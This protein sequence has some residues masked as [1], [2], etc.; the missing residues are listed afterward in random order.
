MLKLYDYFRSSAC[1]RV[2]IALNLKQLDYHIV[3]IHLVENGGEQHS[4]DYQQINPQQLVPSLDI[5]GQT[6]TQSLA[7][8]EY[9]EETYPKPALLPTNSYER[10]IARSYAQII[11]ADIHPL[12]NL[13]VLNYLTHDL[14]IS[15]ASKDTWYQHWIQAGLS[16]LEKLIDKHHLSGDFCI[17]FVPTIAD[18]CLIPQL[19]NARRFNCDLTAYPNLLRIEANCKKISAFEYAFPKE[20]TIAKEIAHA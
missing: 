1:Y 20:P 13:R 7:I 3:P 6:I 4:T 18:I 14:K 2:R 15:N 5:E 12:N 19:Y 9:L 17:G 8:I 11:A 10:A 16:T